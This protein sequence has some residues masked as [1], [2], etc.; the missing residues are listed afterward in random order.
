GA[1]TLRVAALLALL[2]LPA[3][4]G[5]N[6]TSGG[7]SGTTSGG[8]QAVEDA[9]LASEDPGVEQGREEAAAKALEQLKELAGS[10]ASKEDLGFAPDDDV[11]K[12]TLGKPLPVR[13]AR[14]DALKAHQPGTA[15]NKVFFPIQQA[16]YP[17]YV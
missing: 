17:V 5:C 16:F 2:A 7:T 1:V 9:G 11:A 8:P 10:A 14:L 6:E 13:F 15:P 3:C 4:R 12:A